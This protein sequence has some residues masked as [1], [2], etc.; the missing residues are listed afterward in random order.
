MN[1]LALSA[2]ILVG[3]IVVGFIIFYLYG[4]SVRD[5]AIQRQESVNEAWANVQGAYQRRA[6]LIGNLVE[7]VRAAAENEKDILVGV[8]EARAGIQHHTDSVGNLIREQREALS[9]AGTP[10]ELDA[11]DMALMTTY[12]GFKGF[13]TENYPTV[14]AN[15]NFSDLQVS[16]EGTENRI[17]TARDRFNE[18][19][20]EYN[21]LIRGTWRRMGLR[22]VADESDNLVARDMFEAK[23]GADEAPKVKF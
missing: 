7:T 1:K 17:N 19:V 16:L 22:L 6:D 3:T 9:T 15:K 8:T 4:A 10:Q 11:R 12:R 21:A 5:N 20:K 2:I 18:A 13:L 23:P 14:Q